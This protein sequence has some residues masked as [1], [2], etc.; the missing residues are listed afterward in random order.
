MKIAIAG[1]GMEGEANYA[2]WNSSDN[3]VTIVDEQAV[4]SYSL[5][6][7]ATTILG[8][9]AFNQLNGFDLIVR[10]AGLAPTK[11]ITDG[12]VWTATNEFFAKCPALIIGV[13]GTKGKGTTASLIASIFEAAG[14]KVW[15]VGNIGVPALASLSSISPSD[16]VVYELSSFQ[17]WDLESSPH[18][19]VVLPVEPDHL[20]VHADFEDYVS[21]KA[22]IRRHQ[23]SDDICIFHPTNQFSRIIAESSPVGAMQRYTIIDDGGVYVKEA[24]FY[25]DEHKICSVEALQLIGQHNIENA[26]AAITAAKAYGTS[27]NDIEKGLQAFLG[28]PHRLEFV[29]DVAG[30]R[31]YNDSFSSAPS[32]TV[33]AVMS[34]DQPEI[35]IMGGTDK[36]ADFSELVQLITAKENIKKVIIMGEIRKKLYSEI[37]KLNQ[38]FPVEITDSTDLKSIVERAKSYA[39][40]GDVVVLSPGCASFD[41]FNNFY[42]RGDQFKAVVSHL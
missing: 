7:G 25:Q 30:V 26:C 1:Y 31:Y 38:D 27:D 24:S 39:Q 28:L 14:K 35:I 8:E 15:L 20:N 6:Q 4:P 17:L 9:N 3:D 19:A 10:T 23:T 16:I 36:G 2:Y 33:A 41:M 22:N 12:K 29:R 13:T 21:A 32:A 11:L 37:I 18:I 5:P 40:R 34:F 42:D